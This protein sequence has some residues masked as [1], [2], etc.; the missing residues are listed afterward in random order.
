MSQAVVAAVGA[1]GAA[2]S[3]LVFFSS[4][5]KLEAELAAI[6]GDL[7]QIE[8]EKF[9]ALDQVDELQQTV[10]EL[11]K[12]FNAT[13]AELT[14]AID[15]RAAKES[16]NG[17]LFAEKLKAVNDV[18]VRLKAELQTYQSQLGKLQT[19]LNSKQDELDD[20]NAQRDIA[21]DTLHDV[22]QEK[23]KLFKELKDAKEKA[24]KAKETPSPPPPTNGV[25][26]PPAQRFQPVEDSSRM[27]ATQMGAAQMG[28]T[29][30]GG[31]KLDA[32]QK[33]RNDMAHV[34][35]RL[36]TEQLSSTEQTE[37]MGQVAS[38]SQTMQALMRQPEGSTG[39]GNGH[40]GAGPAPI[41]MGQLQGGLMGQASMGQAQ[42]PQPQ[43]QGMQQQQPQQ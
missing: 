13:K 3:G 15:Q 29:Q 28:A 2:A 24:D 7:T 34:K 33:I 35:M 31:S 6:E 20:A 27:G 37:L 9:D 1:I 23:E 18:N 10:S 36:Q 5:K 42:H 39:D 11:Q 16:A 12:T 32:M 4:K 41:S 30:T 19:E 22:V 40:P 26:Q 38:M 21:N 43:Q 17:N 14:A 8:N 25:A